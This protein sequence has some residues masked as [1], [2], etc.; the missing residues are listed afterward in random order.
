MIGI[1]AARVLIGDK[2]VPWSDEDLQGV[3]TKCEEFI[4]DPKPVLDLYMI[5]I[6]YAG[7]YI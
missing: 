6:T 7:S 4:K 2:N 3:V 1:G 5:N